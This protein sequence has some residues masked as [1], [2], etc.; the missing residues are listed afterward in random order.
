[1]AELVTLSEVKDWL[2]DQSKDRDAMLTVLFGVVQT[3][4]EGRTGQDFS[5]A[6]TGLTDQPFDGTGTELLVMPRPPSALNADIKVGQDVSDPDDT[7][8]QA[9]IIAVPEKQW[10]MYKSGKVFPK[11][12]RNLFIDYD[13]AANFPALAKLAV[14]EATAYLW[15]RIGKE[16]VSAETIGEFGNIQMMGAKLNRLQIWEQAVGS[17]RLYIT[18]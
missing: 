11:G 5:D 18:V 10:L 8:L 16:H 1:M 15:R 9:D 13:A 14:L 3:M 7:L 6:T 12:L 4:L 2:N 17:L